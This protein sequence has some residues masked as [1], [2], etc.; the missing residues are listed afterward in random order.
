ML[1]AHSAAEVLVAYSAGEVLVDATCDTWAGLERA[2]AALGPDRIYVANSALASADSG[3]GPTNLSQTV[4]Q[5]TA[6]VQDKVF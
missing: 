1:A 6:L 2:A 4:D 5:V 3:N